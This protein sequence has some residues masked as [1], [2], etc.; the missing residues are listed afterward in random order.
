MKIERA[1]LRE[2]P[3]RLREPFEISSGV[4]ARAKDRAALARL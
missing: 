2:I 3:L 4:D 1:V